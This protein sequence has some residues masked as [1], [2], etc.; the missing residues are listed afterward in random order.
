MILQALTEHY[1]DLLALNK[2]TKP[3]WGLNKV[4]YGINLSD[5][6]DIIAS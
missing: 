3:G 6:G 5:N 1:E 2:T 4:S